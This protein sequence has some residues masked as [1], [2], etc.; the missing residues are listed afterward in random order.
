MPNESLLSIYYSETELAYF[1][2]N[3]LVGDIPEKFCDLATLTLYADCDEV[4]CPC[5]THCCD[6][7]GDCPATGVGNPF[8][9]SFNP[10]DPYPSRS[11][12][13]GAGPPPGMGGP[14]G[15]GPPG[16]APPD[17]FGAPP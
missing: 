16:D 3:D 5:C 4:S 12:I 13:F 14:P 7:T 10:F 11:G 17:G 9:E 8:E 6:A 15:N 1:D 2:G